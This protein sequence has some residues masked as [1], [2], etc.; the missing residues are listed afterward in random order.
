MDRS[1][2]PEHPMR[3]GR[4]FYQNYQQ[5]CGLDKLAQLCPRCDGGAC[6][7]YISGSV[8]VINS[9][10]EGGIDF[11]QYCGGCVDVTTGIRGDC[12]T[13]KPDPKPDPDPTPKPDPDPTPKPDPDSNSKPWKIIAVIVGV[14]ILAIL[15]VYFII[16]SQ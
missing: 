11:K 6:T 15:L 4:Y 3:N 7:C 12:K 8:D 5:R 10:V 1:R 9:Q 13:P 14:V 16:S 2:M